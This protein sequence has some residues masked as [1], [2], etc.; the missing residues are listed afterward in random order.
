MKMDT[1]NWTYY[2]EEKEKKKK[3][4]T[5][6]G[7]WKVGIGPCFDVDNVTCEKVDRSICR[8]QSE[9]EACTLIIKT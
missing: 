6:G 7:T 5:K 3:K 9:N 8:Y 1:D 2:R 4:K